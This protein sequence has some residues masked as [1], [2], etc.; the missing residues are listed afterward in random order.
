MKTVLKYLC[1]VWIFAGV[2]CN[3]ARTIAYADY[4]PQIVVEGWIENGEY[5]QVMLSW[6]ASFSESLDTIYLLKQVIRSAK[7][8]VSD[9][10]QTEVLA[11]GV[12][13]DYLPP[14]VYYGKNLKGEV[15]KTYHLEVA[16]REGIIS[17]ETTIPPPVALDSCWFEKTAP[18]DTVGYVFIQFRNTSDDFYQVATRSPARYLPRYHRWSASQEKVFTPCL[19][20]NFPAAQY[21]KNDTVRM[22]IKRGPRLFLYAEDYYAAFFSEYD[23]IEIK[24]RTMSQAGYD[25]WCSWQNEIINARNPIFPATSNLKSNIDGGIGNWCGYGVSNYTIIPFLQSAE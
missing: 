11:L 4:V 2:A 6:S 5:P 17:A 7:V 18:A 3:E 22:Q 12:N 25:F 23:K 1:G 21:G 10:E 9:G 20:G 13:S 16:Y 8:T 24:F 19:Y 15:G 14:Y